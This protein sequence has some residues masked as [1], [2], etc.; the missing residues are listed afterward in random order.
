M[1][2]VLASSL[3]GFALL[4]GGCDPCDNVVEVCTQCGAAGGCATD[5]RAEVCV[6]A[7]CSDTTDCGEG[8]F[9][10]DGSC[11]PILCL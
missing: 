9:C 6:G 8:G 4:V 7:S 2:T 11:E 10:N 3:V 1:R 5:E